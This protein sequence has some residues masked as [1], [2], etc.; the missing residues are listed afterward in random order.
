MYRNNQLI[1][2][3]IIVVAVVVVALWLG[4]FFIVANDAESSVAGAAVRGV[5]SAVRYAAAGCRVMPA[6]APEHSFSTN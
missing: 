3:V 2:I 4:A 6:S 1:F 5:V